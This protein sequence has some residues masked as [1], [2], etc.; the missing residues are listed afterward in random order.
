MNRVHSAA[1]LPRK[2]ELS[3]FQTQGLADMVI[4]QLGV[5]HVLQPGRHLYGRADNSPRD[6]HQH[7][8]RLVADS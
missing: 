6:Y 7:G 2:G 8:L 4:G 5:D 1:F 3:T